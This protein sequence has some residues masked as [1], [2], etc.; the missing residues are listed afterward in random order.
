LRHAEYFLRVAQRSADRWCSGE[1]ERILA[2]LRVNHG[3]LRVAF[4][5]FL[6]TQEYHGKALQLAAVLRHHWYGG[7]FLS[8]GRRWLEEALA[9]PGQETSRRARALWAAAWVCLLQGDGER[10]DALLDE[11]EPLATRVADAESMA[12]LTC[13][14]GTSALFVGKLDT[15][16][17]YFRSAIAQSERLDLPSCALAAGF[18]LAISLSH[19][20]MYA[21]AGV[22]NRAELER[23]E[24]YGEQWCRSYTLWSSAFDHWRQGDYARALELTEAGIRIQARFVDPLGVAL[25][26]EL[27]AWVN[28]SA[29][30]YHNSARL[31]AIAASM[32]DSIGTR[33]SAI[34]PHLAGHGERCDAQNRRHLSA[35]EHRSARATGSKLT[36]A[37]AMELAL[38][39]EVPSARAIHEPDVTLTRRELQVATLVAQGLTNRAIAASLVVSPRTIDGHVE[40]ILAK[41]GFATR[42]QIATWMAKR[43][44]R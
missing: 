43:Q 9:L 15:S 7:G 37:R 27:R 3:N 42:A 5:F 38:D 8:D 6:G 21:E 17:A 29:G 35:A 26:V 22:V 36:L 39:G 31:H 25:L 4:R 1:Q 40:H 19:K 2:T 28:C 13:L 10:A 24:Q 20:G 11:C 12:F 16:I 44:V 32:W 33:I 34:G 30:N 14:R 41:L 18:Q 23:G